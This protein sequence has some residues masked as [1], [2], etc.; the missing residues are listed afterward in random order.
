M[1]NL[2]TSNL[3]PLP[4]PP[5]VTER[6]VDC[7]STAGLSFHILEAGRDDTRQRP[8]LL[9][10]H[11]FPELAFSWR[12]IMLP[13]A[14]AGY[15]VVAVDLRGYGR[16]TGW[17]DSSFEH[18]DLSQFSITNLVRDH[19]I[20]VSALGYTKVRCVIGHDFGAVPSAMG[21]L[22]R[23]DIFTHCVI[24]SHPHKMPGGAPFNTANQPSSS[25]NASEPSAGSSD[26]IAD[27]TALDPPRK[28]YK[29]D[30]SKPSAAHD[31]ANPPQ[32]LHA[33]LRGYI[34]LKSANWSHNNPHPLKSW[35]AEELAKMPE[36]Y[37]MPLES[38]M[39]SVVSKHMSTEDAKATTSWLS[40]ADLDFY[41][42]EWSRTGFQGGL[43]FYRVATNP[44]ISK[45]MLLFSGRKIEV[46]TAFI[47]GEK[48]WGNY[49][50]PGA[51]EGMQ[52][53]ESVTDFRGFRVV[54]G[55]GHWPQQEQPEKVVE[56]IL[57]FLDE[58]GGLQK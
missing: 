20:L 22:M 7:L 53:G 17:D 1:S 8:L 35:T 37:I 47:S 40:D 25:T 24:M 16:T 36:Y 5:G 6:Q 10:F 43:N 48:D 49:Q 57:K 4:L 21:T 52:R 12:K 27:L 3:P 9:L 29:Y 26:I 19:V 58:T 45:D 31:W 46:P 13:L 39:A 33:F 18:V 56:E 44:E 55:A 23:P 51:L 41:V 42:Q 38:T 2:S 32:G 30:N 15:Y 34:H 28:H 14:K 54:E 50:Q 11:G